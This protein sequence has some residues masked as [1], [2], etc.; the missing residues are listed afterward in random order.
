MNPPLALAAFTTAMVGPPI[1]SSTRAKSAAV[2]SGPGTLNF[3]VVP[4]PL[5]WPINITNSTSPVLQRAPSAVSSRSMFS[6]VDAALIRV[7][8]RDGFSAR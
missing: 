5:P 4:S 7:A 2:M 8:S 3:D 1:P 6:F